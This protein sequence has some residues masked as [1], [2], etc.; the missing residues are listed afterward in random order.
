MDSPQVFD[1]ELIIQSN[2]AHFIIFAFSIFSIGWGAYN[3]FAVSTSS[4]RHASASPEQ[5]RPRLKSFHQP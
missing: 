2:Y 3:A 5:K 1:T 4:D